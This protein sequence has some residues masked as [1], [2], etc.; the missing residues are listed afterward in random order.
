M[1]FKKEE[2]YKMNWVSMNEVGQIKF[3]SGKHIAWTM[4]FWFVAITGFAGCHHI[5]PFLQHDHGKH[6]GHHKHARVESRK[7]S[8]NEVAHIMFDAATRH[9][10]E[11]YFRHHPDYF[12]VADA[13][14]SGSGHKGKGKGKGMP[15][16]LA[17]KKHLPPGLAKRQTLPPGLQKRALPGDLI[18][19]LPPPH[20]DAERVVIDN[21]VLL[22][23]KT[24]RLVL[25]IIDLAI[26]M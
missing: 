15:P 9:V 4:A 10:I 8:G 11:D 3:R 18:R 13:S 20:P 16:G 7:L 1:L 12:R 24:T 22:I 23:H 2:K 19:K 21:K 6:K 14:Y 5:F 25:D 26:E 17:K